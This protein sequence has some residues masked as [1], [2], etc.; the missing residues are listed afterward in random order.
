LAESQDNDETIVIGLDAGWDG[1]V[2][3]RRVDGTRVAHAGKA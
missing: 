3:K 1:D 2:V